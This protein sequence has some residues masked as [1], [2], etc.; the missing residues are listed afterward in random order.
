MNE[1]QKAILSECADRWFKNPAGITASDLGRK[2]G[3]SNE[4][5]CKEVASSLVT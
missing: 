3:I 4:E 5:T 1:I 2:F